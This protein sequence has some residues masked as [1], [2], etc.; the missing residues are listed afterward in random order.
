MEL[1][2]FLLMSIVFSICSF[3]FAFS[4]EDSMPAYLIGLIGL[5]FSPVAFLITVHFI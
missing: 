4:K 3:V 1:L 5:L 2:L